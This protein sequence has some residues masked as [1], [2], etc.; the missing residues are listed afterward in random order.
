MISDFI[1]T[2]AYTRYCL[3]II[4]VF[5]KLF[6]KHTYTHKGKAHPL[7]HCDYTPLERSLSIF[8]LCTKPNFSFIFSLL[9][10]LLSIH[11]SIHHHSPDDHLTHPHAPHFFIAISSDASSLPPYCLAHSFEFEGVFFCENRTLSFSLSFFLL[12]FLLTSLF[13]NLII[14]TYYS[15]IVPTKHTFI[16]IITFDFLYFCFLFLVYFLAFS[17]FSVHNSYY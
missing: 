12:T 13:F 17:F 8:F 4:R 16:A 1:T 6:S 3:L 11:P 10:I 9:A 5:S 14:Q 15:A 7:E 2:I